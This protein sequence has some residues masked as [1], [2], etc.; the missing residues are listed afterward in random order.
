MICEPDAIRVRS[1]IRYAREGDVRL[2]D[3]VLGQFHA[4]DRGTRSERIGHRHAGTHP[5]IVRLDPH[6]R[7]ARA[8]WAPSLIPVSRPSS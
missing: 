7:L 1:P 4:V 6:T 5:A 3:N 2:E 8:S